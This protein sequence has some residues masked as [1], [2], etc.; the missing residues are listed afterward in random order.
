[1]Q[2]ILNDS[3]KTINQSYIL[4]VLI[5]SYFPTRSE[6]HEILIIIL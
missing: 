2:Y 5:C 4:F 1:M 6:Q 3:I